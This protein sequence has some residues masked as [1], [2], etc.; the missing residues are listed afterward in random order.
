[1]RA[2]TYDTCT[3]K[4]YGRCNQN[5]SRYLRQVSRAS[6]TIYTDECVR[7]RHAHALCRIG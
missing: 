4:K 7:A 6:E 2:R 1:M 5:R 3:I